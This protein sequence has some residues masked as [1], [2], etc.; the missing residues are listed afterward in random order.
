MFMIPSGFSL[1]HHTLALRY[2]QIPS[3][4]AMLPFSRPSLLHVGLYRHSS[5]QLRS[6]IPYKCMSQAT[7]TL[8]MSPQSSEEVWC[9][10]DGAPSYFVAISK[11]V[12]NRLLGQDAGSKC[13]KKKMTFY[14]GRHFA[15]GSVEHD[16]SS[17]LLTLVQIG[18]RS[19]RASR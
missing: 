8:Q 12:G 11:A 17:S 9:R 1:D 14:D 3:N 6:S 16:V 19:I 7:A 18:L 15:R 10:V 2:P 5:C 4:F 13:L